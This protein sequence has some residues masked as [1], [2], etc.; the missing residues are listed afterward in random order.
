MWA[1]LVAAGLA[2]IVTPVRADFSR[3]NGFETP[4]EVKRPPRQM[5][6]TRPDDRQVAEEDRIYNEMTLS[7]RDDP[8]ARLRFWLM[9]SGGACVVLGAVIFALLRRRARSG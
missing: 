4:G 6:T 5:V 8:D 2:L 1:A 3:S 9:V 7:Q